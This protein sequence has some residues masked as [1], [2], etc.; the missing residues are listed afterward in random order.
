[1]LN[2]LDSPKLRHSAEFEVN[3]I[4]SRYKFEQGGML[5]YDVN[6]AM[7]KTSTEHSLPDPDPVEDKVQS[8]LKF[9][10]ISEEDWKLLKKLKT[11]PVTPEFKAKHLLSI[12]DDK[13]TL[14]FNSKF[15][16]GNLYKAVK[17][18]DY[19]YSLQISADMNTTGNNHWYYFSVRNPRRTPVTFHITNMKKL[20]LLYRS[21]QKPVVYSLMLESE[22][23]TKWHRDCTNIA[24][25]PVAKSNYYCLSFT[26]NFRYENDLVYFA[27]SIPYTYSDLISDLEVLQV[28]YAGILRVNTLCKTLLGNSCPV[29]TITDDIRT[30]ENFQDESSDYNSSSAGRRL[31]RLK[32]MKELEEKHKAK[33]SVVMTARV[34]PGETVSSFMM[35][36]VIQYLIDD[37]KYAKLLRRNFV[38]K[39]VPMLN[40][41]GVRYGNY[42]CCLMGADLN[43][44]WSRPSKLLHP[45]VFSTKKMMQVLH[46]THPISLFCDMHGHSRKKNVFMY[47]CNER[48]QD[49]ELHKKNLLAKFIPVVLAGENKLFSFNDCH[50]RLEKDKMSTA[51]IV[52]FKELEIPHSYTIEAS[53]FGPKHEKQFEG[54]GN[55]DGHMSE[56]HLAG[57]GESLCKSLIVLCS[58]TLFWN[59]LRAVNEFLKKRAL[60]LGR[61]RNNELSGPGARLLKKLGSEGKNED[62]ECEIGK[63]GEGQEEI[64]DIEKQE[65]KDRDKVLPVEL[66]EIGQVAGGQFEDFWEQ[67]DIVNEEPSDE[68]SGGSDSCPSE[69]ESSAHRSKS[70]IRK[71]NRI[72]KYKKSTSNNKL[73]RLNIGVALENTKVPKIQ[74]AK[75]SIIPKFKIPKLSVNLPV[76]SPRVIENI[77][78]DRINASQIQ[79]QRKNDYLAAAVDKQHSLNIIK[80]K[81]VKDLLKSEMQSYSEVKSY[82]PMI[83]PRNYK[84]LTISWNGIN[85]KEFAKRVANELRFQKGNNKGQ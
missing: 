20:D 56:K 82:K 78:S 21:G 79:S 43:R 67:F 12:P 34:H 10:G 44:R 53:F 35:K 83:T 58:P 28:Q 16:S 22:L 63:I 55:G 17:L 47:G 36:G 50:F 68:D 8:D 52:V 69:R 73:Q 38:F 57:I 75:I 54:K 62:L 32:K 25:T 4:I 84:L 9:K 37:R 59:K 29:I 60:A 18:S 66:G 85:P 24:Y 48:G 45:T 70:A 61:F 27:Y 74:P 5:V 72:D 77:K 26:Y 40:P 41:D 42:R 1:M 15:E 65:E 76:V 2:L 14:E 49:F 13:I 6:A 11:L 7:V 19:E 81:T 23:N 39:L 71:V 3:P 64:E 33:K 80:R 31:K 51:R 30:Y 46:E